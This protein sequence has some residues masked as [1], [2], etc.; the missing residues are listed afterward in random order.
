[1]KIVKN[2]SELEIK[3]EEKKKVFDPKKVYKNETNPTKL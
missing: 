1:M 3:F 2:T